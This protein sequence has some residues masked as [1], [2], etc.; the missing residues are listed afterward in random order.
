MPRPEPPWLKDLGFTTRQELREAAAASL[1]RARDRWRAGAQGR[2]ECSRL[3]RGEKDIRRRHTARDRRD[4]EKSDVGDGSRAQDTPDDDPS[5]ENE[6]GGEER[7][8]IVESEHNDDA[9]EDFE[10]TEAPSGETCKG[11]EA[12]EAGE[13]C[14]AD[15]E[16]GEYEAEEK[17]NRGAKARTED[18]TDW[19]EAELFSDD[20]VKDVKASSMGLSKTD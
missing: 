19:N 16:D 5:R 12:G 7:G 18:P 8:F 3:S 6:T 15:D 13:A 14:E 11:G 20:D 17:G 10:D 4:F 1:R 2:M 9:G